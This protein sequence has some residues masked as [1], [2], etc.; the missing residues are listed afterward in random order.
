MKLIIYIL[1]LISSVLPFR[2][3]AEG[4]PKKDSSR[5]K[6]SPAALSLS[7]TEIT[8]QRLVKLVDSLLDL[9]S[10]EE[11]DIELISY[12]NS[13][14]E[15][16]TVN[17]AEIKLGNIP[18]TG[19][20]EDFDETT[21]FHIT[22]ENEFPESQVIV[23]ENDS[24]GTYH[25]PRPGPVNSK[26]GWRDGR[27]HKGIDINL[28]K[29]DPVVAAFDGMVRIAHAKGAYGNVV[30][31]R[32]Y[33]G[34]ETVY[35]HLS[36]IKV[37]P[38]Q[39]VLAGQL[40]G[41]GGSTGRSSGPHLHFEVRFK[42]QALNPASLISFSEGKTLHDSIVIKRSRY[43]ICAFPSNAKLHTIERGDSWYEV[44]KRYGLTMK[45][46]CALNGTDKR[47]YL[48]IGQK[49]RVN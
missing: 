22:P 4:E 6:I 12:Y 1:V 24:L 5:L 25:H 27:M 31:I 13:I 26:F 19:F 41:L 2:L 49:L 11:K 47:Y 36:R 45:E 30:I 23:I 20:Y 3:K 29:G 35:A 32:H 38:G 40:I 14:L 10:I 7:K 48:K 42:G 46:L 16:K 9:E 33:N 39:V 21:V 18:A 44:A 8:R 43:G 34:L 15:S 37:K 17:L 28:H